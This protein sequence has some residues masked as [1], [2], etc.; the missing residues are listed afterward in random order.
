MEVGWCY[1]GDLMSG[2]KDANPKA[3]RAQLA[4]QLVAVPG[5]TA[6]AER[7]LRMVGLSHTMT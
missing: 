2:A 5:V 4:A 7:P 6:A 1:Q 3:E